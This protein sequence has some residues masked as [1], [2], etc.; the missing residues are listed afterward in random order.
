LLDSVPTGGTE[1]IAL[2][3]VTLGALAMYLAVPV[4]AGAVAYALAGRL[5]IMPGV[6]VGLAATVIGAGFF[7]GLVGGIL[8]GLVTSQLD[9]LSRPPWLRGPASLLIVPLSATLAS[10]VAMLVVI[11]PPLA[12]ASRALATWLTALDGGSAVLLGAILGAMMAADL[13]G[14]LN[15][16]A[17]SFAVAGISA[18]SVRDGHALA[19][20]AAV[21]TA[22]MTAPLAC[23]AAT[24]VR[25]SLFT[26]AERRN[27]RAAGVLGALFVTEGAIPFAAARPV[28]VIPSLMLGSSIAA[29]A[30]EA[31]GATLSVPHGGLFA[32]P[33]VGNLL[34]FM[35][36][37]ALGITMTAGCLVLCRTV[38]S[39]RET[40][41]VEQERSVVKAAAVV[42]SEGPVS[43]H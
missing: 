14:P 19:V 9:R 26:L 18:T 36:S 6:T 29:A 27:G 13:G 7:G 38:T 24:A 16:A 39:T 8:A 32:L 42:P 3:L 28:T 21:M 33:G 17:Y 1:H 37:L 30:S 31:F 15:K 40:A 35:T 11:G 20:M 43:T 41:V 2:A 5:A 10:G 4:L 12:A 22:G 25:P 34:G 23:W